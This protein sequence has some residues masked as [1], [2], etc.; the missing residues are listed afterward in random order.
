MTRGDGTLK[1]PVDV[2]ANGVDTRLRISAISNGFIV[3]AGGVPVHYATKED[4][5]AAVASAVLDFATSAEAALQE[6]DELPK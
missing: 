2:T 6:L 3:K 4:M 5:A 1:L